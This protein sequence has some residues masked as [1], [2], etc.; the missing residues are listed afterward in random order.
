MI[1]LLKAYGRYEGRFFLLFVML[2]GSMIAMPFVGNVVPFILFSVIPIAGVQ[3]AAYNRRHMFIAIV[4]GVPALTFGLGHALPGT[5]SS[6][7]AASLSAVGFYGY[8][9]AIV[10]VFVLRQKT[11]TADTVYGALSVYL[12]LGMTWAFGYTGIEAYSPGSFFI[13]ADYNVDGL[14]NQ[15]DFFYY[16]FVTLTT[17]GYGDILPISHTARMLAIGEAACG[18]LYT[19]TLVASVVSRLKLQHGEG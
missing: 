17:L 18:V 9:A 7:W 8:T 15:R 5:F 10:F 4:L 11:I 12:L 1:R 16:S 2:V 13:D 6:V 19:A 3:A 14:L